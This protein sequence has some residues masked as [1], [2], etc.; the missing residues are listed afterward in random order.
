MSLEVKSFDAPDEV[1][2]LPNV[3][4]KVVNFGNGPVAQ[5]T[6]EPGWHWSNDVKP[7][8]GTASCQVLHVGYVVSGRLKIV[9]DDGSTAEIGPGD[10]FRLAPGHDAWTDGDQPCVLVDFGGL[11][12]DTEPH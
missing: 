12:A 4:V 6:Y 2:E 1:R 10:V 7:V 9:A 3:T 8:A 5:G 11:H